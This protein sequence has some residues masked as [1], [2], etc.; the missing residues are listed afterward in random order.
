MDKDVDISNDYFIFHNKG[1]YDI[2]TKQFLNTHGHKYTL[3]QLYELLN[4]YKP[5]E[6]RF[7]FPWCDEYK[8]EIIKY[9]ERRKNHELL[10]V[11]TE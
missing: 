11:W 2:P 6:R 1:F 7:S 10:K 3:L 8:N 4:D 5:Y 9:I